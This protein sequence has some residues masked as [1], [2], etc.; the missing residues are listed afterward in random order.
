MLLVLD[1]LDHLNVL[2]VLSVLNVLDL[3]DVL[4][5][6]DVLNGSLPFLGPSSACIPRAVS[7]VGMYSFTFEGK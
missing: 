6:F 5:V 2:D 3:L 4:N 7:L 1:V